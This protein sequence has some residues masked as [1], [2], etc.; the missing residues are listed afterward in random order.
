MVVGRFQV[1]ATLQAARAFILGLP[2]DM[3]LSWGLNRAIFYAAAKRGFK[4]TKMPERLRENILE[5]PVL[6]E[7]NRYFLGD[8]MAYKTEDQGRTYFVI[9]GK[10]QTVEDFKKNV[11]YRFGRK[12]KIIWKEA[13]ELIEGFDKKILLSQHEFYEKVYRPQRDELAKKWTELTL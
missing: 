6:E 12:F 10:L 11:E 13:L 5:K 8:E 2:L 4:K 9:G 1:M 3:S 7:K